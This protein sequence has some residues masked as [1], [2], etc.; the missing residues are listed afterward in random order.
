MRNVHC[1]LRTY[2]VQTGTK[3]LHKDSP[4]CYTCNSNI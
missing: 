2:E 1:Q 4:N 3:E